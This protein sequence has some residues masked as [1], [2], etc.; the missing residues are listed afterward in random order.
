MPII[1]GAYLRTRNPALAQAYFLVPTILALGSGALWDGEAIRL[2][3]YSLIHRWDGLGFECTFFSPPR[4]VALVRR[5]SGGIARIRSH[6]YY[7]GCISQNTKSRVGP[8][9]F[10]RAD[11]TRARQPRTL[12][13]GVYPTV[14]YS[15]LIHCWHGL[16]F[17]RTFFSPPGFFK[18][19]KCSDDPSVFPP[20]GSIAISALPVIWHGG[21]VLAARLSFDAT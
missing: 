4:P 18:V 16:G 5:W 7:L 13:R 17:K 2:R 3:Y 9:I 11:G 20:Q 8:S 15:W 1:L 14:R 19:P 12:G 21:I 6:A 10:L